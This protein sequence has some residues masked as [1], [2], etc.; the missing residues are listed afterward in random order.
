MNPREPDWSLNRS[1]LAV[2]EEGSLPAAAR[3]LGLTQALE[4]G[5]GLKLFVRSREGLRPTEGVRL[6]AMASHTRHAVATG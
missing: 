1:F 5:F 3:L 4:Q 6:D 2:P